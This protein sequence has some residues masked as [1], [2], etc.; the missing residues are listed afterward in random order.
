MFTVRAYFTRKLKILEKFVKVAIYIG[1][2]N[3]EIFTD[4]KSSIEEFQDIIRLRAGKRALR[5]KENLHIKLTDW[6]IIARLV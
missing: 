3:D 5:R 6:L 4:K 2:R 1:Q